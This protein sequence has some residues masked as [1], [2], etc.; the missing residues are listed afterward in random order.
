MFVFIA[1]TLLQIPMLLMSHSQWGHAAKSFV[2]PSIS[3]GVSSDAVLLIIAIV[4]TTV[5]P[6]SCFFSSPTSS[7]SASPPDSWAMNGPTPSWG[8]SS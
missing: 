3:G 8:L 1:V 4:G 6:G 7:T 5:A 2:V